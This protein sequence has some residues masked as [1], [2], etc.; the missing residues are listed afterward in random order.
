MGSNSQT[1]RRLFERVPGQAAQYGSSPQTSGFTMPNY[2]VHPHCGLMNLDRQ[3]L[4]I[5]PMAQE[6]GRLKMTRVTRSRNHPKPSGAGLRSLT[7]RYI[8]S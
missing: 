6:T 4:A 5:T 8:S 2:R 3:L 7:Y 1:A